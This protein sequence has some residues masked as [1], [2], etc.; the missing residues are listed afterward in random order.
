MK[1]IYKSEGTVMK[2]KQ[3][4]DR[5]LASEIFFKVQVRFI[6]WMQN[7]AFQV[8]FF[9]YFYACFV[10]ITLL[11]H[12]LNQ[13]CSFFSLKILKQRI[14]HSIYSWLGETEL[15]WKN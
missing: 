15:G 13:W 10:I 8:I 12:F 3:S 11:K 9:R 2:L 7:N 6:M 14:I 1:T 5:G 4:Q